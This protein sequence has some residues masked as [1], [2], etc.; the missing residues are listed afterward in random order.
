MKERII[1]HIDCNNAFLSWTAVDM[2]KKGAKI[3]IRTI[4]AIIGGDEETRHG[5]VL[6]K[7]PIAKKM[8]IKTGEPVY[9]A[10][11][12]C[13]GLKMFETNFECYKK[14]SNLLYNLFLEYTD[15]VERFSIDEC[16]LDMTGSIYKSET[17]LSKAEEISNRIKN[18]YGF[19]VNIGI[20]HN[21]LLAKMASD[22][23]KPDK[24]HT[25]YE[26]EIQSKMW[27]LPVSELLFVGKKTSEKLNKMRI[28]TIGDLAHSDKLLLIN[29]FGKF[30]FQMWQYAN[31]IDNSEVNFKQEKPK[32]ISTETTLPKNISNAEDLKKIIV[33]L[34]EEVSYRLRKEN[35]KTSVIA[36]D[37]KTSDFRTY[38]H[39]NKLVN[40]TSNTK[41]ILNEAKKLIDEMYS[42]EEIRLIG[43][44]LDK[45]IDENCSKQISLFDQKENNKLDN[46]DK[47]IDN[48][49]EKYG[50]NTIKRGIN[51]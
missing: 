18:S 37:L 34:V 42:K 17:P 3:D 12:K 50:F 19:T 24:I 7:S 23:E 45:L 47:T 13:P 51:N 27:T 11:Q 4:P 5:I 10:K 35:M 32:S 43:V 15:K 22:F 26:N 39:Q 29:T 20:A 2:L 48:L 14:Y 41:I 8:G 46:L 49:N 31:G 40:P 33:K 30:G 6:A 16:F 25:L 21:K 28:N 36:V 1:L 44:R 38:S 9:F